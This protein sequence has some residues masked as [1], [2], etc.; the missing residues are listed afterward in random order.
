[1]ENNAVF[2]QK[3]TGIFAVGPDISL[4][5]SQVLHLT[6][7]PNLEENILF[8]SKLE[9]RKRWKR[10]TSLFFI[11]MNLPTN[12]FHSQYLRCPREKESAM[13]IWIINTWVYC[14]ICNPVSEILC[15][16]HKHLRV[17]TLRVGVGLDVSISWFQMFQT[18]LG[19]LFLLLSTEKLDKT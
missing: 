19:C 12:C 18:L 9:L 8:L 13:T 16:Y 15:Y 2:W 3:Y 7:F 5:I 17:T 11:R 6:L 10:P 14:L 1:M 4:K